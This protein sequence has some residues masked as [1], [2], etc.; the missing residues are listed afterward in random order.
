MARSQEKAMSALNRWVDQR[1]AIES[2]GTESVRRARFAS[3]CRSVK[4]GE[5]ARAE[6]VQRLSSLISQI[7][8][9]TLGEQKIRD[10]ND[11]INKLLRSKY[12]WEMQI[13]KLGGPDYTALGSSIGEA[14]AV[15][16]PGQGGYKYFGAAKDLPGVSEL[17][18]QHTSVEGARRSRRDLLKF[19]KPDYYGWYDEDDTDLLEHEARAE[20][21]AQHGEDDLRRSTASTLDPSPSRSELYGVLADITAGESVGEMERELVKRKKEFLISTYINPQPQ[22]PQ[23]LASLVADYHVSASPLRNLQNNQIDNIHIVE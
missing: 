7:R 17:L 15:E 20:K 4:E 14:E 11:E 16:L 9:S 13:R 10:L 5:G 2:G 8:N 22:D 23:N 19:I 18:E 21:A 1:K 6:I 3:E 12:A